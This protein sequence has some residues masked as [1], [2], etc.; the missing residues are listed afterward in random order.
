M[1]LRNV[2]YLPVPCLCRYRGSSGENDLCM[3]ASEPNILERENQQVE[4][5]P[6][7]KTAGD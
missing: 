5:S 7:Q 3:G 6:K 4:E 1:N 2:R